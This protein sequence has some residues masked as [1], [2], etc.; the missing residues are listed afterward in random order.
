[1]KDQPPQSALFAEPASGD[2][3]FKKRYFFKLFTNMVGF[4]TG[5]ASQAIVPRALGPAAYGNYSFLTDFFW[6]LIG[7]LNLNSSTALYT[8]ICQRQSEKNLIRFYVGFAVAI[9]CLALLFICL[10]KAC[11]LNQLF[12]P[13]QA[14]VFVALALVLACFRYYNDTL[15]SISDAYKLTIKSELVN[16]SYKIICFVSIL[17]LF[18]FNSLT[19]GSYLCLQILLLALSILFL[20]LVVDKGRKVFLERWHLQWPQVKNYLKEFWLFCSPLIIVAAVSVVTVIFDRWLL[21]RVSG[22]EEQGY[23]SLGYQIGS[24][25]ILVTSA[26]IPLVFREYA[27]SLGKGDTG[28]FKR[29]LLRFT[30]ML[31]AISAYFSCFL[32]VEAKNV[33]ALFGGK[34]FAPALFAVSLMCLY[35]IHQTLGQLNASVFFSA[36]KTKVYRN[37]GVGCAL[38][39]ALVSLLLLG[40]KEYGG[41]A[42]GAN[43]LSI[44]MVV[45]QFFS[46]NIQLFYINKIWG[47]GLGRLLSHQ[48]VVIILFLASAFACS[49]LAQSLAGDFHFSI[50]FLLSGTMY[51]AAIAFFALLVPP[52]FSTTRGEMLGVV[53]SIKRGLLRENLR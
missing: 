21:Q 20:I 22:S 2:V 25:C 36:H 14:M 34:A 23:Y 5:I 44:K 24:V 37:I 35:P 49:R 3:S 8:K 29:V 31:Y 43:G 6:Q 47:I 9:V 12:W 10:S 30:P 7:F 27:V 13:D 53:S 33:I 18:I 42:A 16:V 50:S 17:L 11:G 38:A 51:T 39:G 41:F 46:V 45:I 15:V 32:A 4:G 19:L 52:I 28:E 26:M 1:M 40:P 48:F